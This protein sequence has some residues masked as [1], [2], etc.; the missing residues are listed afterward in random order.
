MFKKLLICLGAVVLGQG[1]LQAQ[2]RTCGTMNNLERLEKEFPG[3]KARRARADGAIR[4]WKPAGPANQKTSAAIITIPVVV[5]V[6][7]NSTAQN[8]SQAQIQSQIDA[9]NEDYSRMNGDTTLIPAAF[10]PLLGDMQIRFELAKR[11]PNGDPTN[12]VTRTAT[13]VNSFQDNDAVK[14]A[15]RGG[16]DA[17]NRDKYLNIWVCRLGGGLLGYAQFPSSGPA[18]TDGVVIG[19]SCFG[20]TGT[21][22]PPFNKGRTATHEVGHWLGLLH[23]WGDEP[24]CA[25]DDNV[26]DTPQQKDMNF[27]CPT[28]PLL[29]GTGAACTPGLPGSMFMNYMDYVDD[30]CMY[31]F[32]NGQKMRSQAALNIS[33]SPLF[34]SDGLTPVVLQPLDAKVFRV[35]APKS[36]ST[37]NNFVTPRF[38]LKNQGTTTLT[39]ATITYKLDNG[40]PQTLPW[41]GS[42]ASLATTTITLPGLTGLAVGTHTY[43]ISTSLPNGQADNDA[44]NDSQTASFTVVQQPVGLGLPFAESFEPV[45][46]PPAG[47]TRTNPDNDITWA[48]TLQAAKAGM[49][50]AYMN[51]YDYSYN[52]EVDELIMPALNLTTQASPQL[53]FQV[54]YS[55]S[56]FLIPSDTLEVMVS[57]DCGE[58]YTS[59][60]KKTGQAL[61]TKATPTGTK[62]IPTANEWRL[63]TINLA[64]YAGNNSVILKFKHTTNYENSL[65]LDDVNVNGLLGLKAETFGTALN[66]F[67][68]PAT[69]LV[70]LQHQNLKGGTVMVTNIVGQEILLQPLESK[71]ETVLNLTEKPAGIYL[72][73]VT[74]NGKTFVQK[75]VLTN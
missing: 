30:A 5:H 38:V 21:A 41:T 1:A 61:S 12:G 6:V 3:T 69:G 42:L 58:T 35:D 72:V 49:R 32:T 75:L 24:G 2:H 54:A 70:T 22:V 73:R 16:H 43:F 64:N 4:N 33:R 23:I 13:T 48:R 26:T 50:S 47:W 20:R 27:G 46:F 36:G 63:E 39:S 9:L 62:F 11:D 71:S 7:Y 67:P 10:K 57:T 66:L 45:T 53:T 14:F 18:T 40:T 74:A 31:M 56:S 44:T 28:F 52:G 19:H 15:S 37:C 68:N 60:Y 8:V 59:L 29:T 34:T 55:P 17:W 51:N 25:A 65:Y